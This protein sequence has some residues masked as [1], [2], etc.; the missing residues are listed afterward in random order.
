MDDIPHSMIVNSYNELFIYGTTASADFPI[1]TLAYQPLF[2]GGAPFSPSGIGV[3]FPNGSDLFVSR[4]SADGGNL[5]ASTFIGGTG[6]DGINTATPLRYNYADEI[7]GEIDID[8][9]NNIYI[10]TCTNS[11]DFPTKNSFQNNFKGD[12][13][14][15][16]IKM[17]N[18]LTQIIWSTYLGGSASDAI[19]SLA[20]DE[21][22]DLYVTGGTNSINFP[23][24]LNA[25]QNSYQ[26]SLNAD[27]F[28]TKIS[29]GGGYILA[30]SYF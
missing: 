11:D 1:T 9:Q 14:G 6:N 25:Y 21:N 30:S 22:D 8:K 18:Q 19:Y 12:Q 2:K 28:V 15:C 17:D 7:R 13:E 5:L 23:T 24:T 20:I 3:S 4:L 26:D 10:A 16:V 29:S 27:A